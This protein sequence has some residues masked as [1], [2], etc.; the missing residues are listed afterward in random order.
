MEGFYQTPFERFERFERY[1]PYG[2][3]TDV[4][5]FLASYVAAGSATFNLIP[6][7]PDIET[8]VEA[9]PRSDDCW[10]THERLS[11]RAT[12]V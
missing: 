1:S 6:Q 9:R 12:A 11:Q 7:S 5:E 3:A 10:H 2:T 8:A 4:A